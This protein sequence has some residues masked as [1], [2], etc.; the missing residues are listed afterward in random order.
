VHSAFWPGIDVAEAK[1]IVR[2]GLAYDALAGALPPA[3]WQIADNV[4]ECVNP[5]RP[6]MIMLE[7]TIPEDGPENMTVTSVGFNCSYEDIETEAVSVKTITLFEP[8]SG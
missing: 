1:V 2:F 4:D 7:T 5:L 6:S 3:I 8:S